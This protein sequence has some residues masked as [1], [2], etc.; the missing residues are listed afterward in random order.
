MAL[1][2]PAIGTQKKSIKFKMEGIKGWVAV[3]LAIRKKAEL[4]QF[5][6]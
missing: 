2:E 4:N 6:F 5:K 1:I 3:G